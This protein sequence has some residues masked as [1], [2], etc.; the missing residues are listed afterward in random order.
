[1]TE[2]KLAK[3]N[4]ESQPIYSRRF[5]VKF[6]LI[7]IINFHISKNLK[8]QQHYQEVIGLQIALALIEVIE[9]TPTFMVDVA[10]SQVA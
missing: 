2:P 8:W 7:P 1:M 3:P 5:K 4:L 10:I 9:L 6:F